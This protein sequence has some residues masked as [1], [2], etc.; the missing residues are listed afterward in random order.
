MFLPLFFLFLG[1]LF[2]GYLF[3]DMFIGLGSEF[4]KESIFILPEHST[5]IDFEFLPNIYK[6]SPLLILIVLFYKLGWIYGYRKLNF[7]RFIDFMYFYRI[8]FIFL[9]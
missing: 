6:L 3:K 7:N 8:F 5:L 4:L 1:T 9:L 2:F